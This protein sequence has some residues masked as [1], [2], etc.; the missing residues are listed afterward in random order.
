MQGVCMCSLNRTPTLHLLQKSASAPAHEV[1]V[2]IAQLT[3]F[4]LYVPFIYDTRA[5]F[6]WSSYLVP[7]RSWLDSVF[8]CC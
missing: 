6:K 4:M 8:C 2:A 5:R 3:H 7:Q 1:R